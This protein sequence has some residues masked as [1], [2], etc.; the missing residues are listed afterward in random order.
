MNSWFN[1]F[2]ASS[3]AAAKTSDATTPLPPD[4]PSPLAT[5][6]TRLGGRPQSSKRDTALDSI[7]NWVNEGGAGGEVRR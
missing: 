3:R 6:Q 7:G 5:Q 1:P 4:Q 2:W